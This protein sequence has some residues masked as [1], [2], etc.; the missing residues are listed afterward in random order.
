MGAASLVSASR[1]RIVLPFAV[2]LDCTK[3]QYRRL[4]MRIKLTSLGPIAARLGTGE[5]SR[6]PGNGSARRP[7]N[8]QTS[9]TPYHTDAYRDLLD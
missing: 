9:H 1:I 4:R 3:G 2:L 8:P 6:N 5:V 7:R